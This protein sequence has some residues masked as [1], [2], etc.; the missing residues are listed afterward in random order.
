MPEGCKGGAVNHGE[1]PTAA[2]LTSKDGI[3]DLDF[4]FRSRGGYCHAIRIRKPAQVIVG[5]GAIDEAHPW[6]TIIII[7]VICIDGPPTERRSRRL[8]FRKISAEGAVIKQDVAQAGGEFV[9]RTIVVKCATRTGL[10]VT[11]C[12]VV[13]GE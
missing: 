4:G 6:I 1:M 2:V 3:L 9:G 5:K 7:L 10:I 11:E 13:R 12:A 8:S